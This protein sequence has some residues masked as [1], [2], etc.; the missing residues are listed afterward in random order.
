MKI[1]ISGTLAE[2]ELASKT[3]LVDAVV[4]NPTVI[5]NWTL[6]G[7]SL[8]DV[9]KIAIEQ[10]GLPLYVQL[11]SNTKDDFLREVAYLKNI[12]DKVIPKIPSTLDGIMAAAELEKNGIETLV[13]TVVSVPQAYACA[14]AGVTAIC[15]YLNRLQESGTNAL[16][17]IKNLSSMYSREHIKTKIMPASIRTVSDIEGSLV[18]GCSGVIIFYPLFK[19]MFSHNVTKQS[20]ASFDNDWKNIPYNFK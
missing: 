3:G 6:N 13:T 12:S 7:Q 11:K 19:E 2:I 10:T 8:E 16:D 15:P 1:W 4:T 5:A 18:A 9:I 20:L 14:A 17:F